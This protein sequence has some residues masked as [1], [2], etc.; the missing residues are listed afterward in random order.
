MLLAFP[1]ARSLLQTIFLQLSNIFYIFYTNSRLLADFYEES[2]CQRKQWPSFV[3]I[4]VLSSWQIGGYAADT[5]F[6]PDSIYHSE[7]K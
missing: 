7:K 5:H 6:Y 1:R 2:F 3:K 4:V